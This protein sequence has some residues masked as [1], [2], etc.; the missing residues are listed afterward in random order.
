MEAR[1]ELIV[2]SHKSCPSLVRKDCDRWRVEVEA[3]LPSIVIAAR[4]GSGADLVD[5][6]VTIDDK[7]VLERLDGKAMPIDP[8]THKLRATMAGRSPVEKTFVAREGE[9]LR[10]VDLVFPVES[11]TTASSS[12]APPVRTV[13]GWTLVGAGGLAALLGTYL[14]VRQA[15]EYADAERECA[16]TCPM[17]RK[18]EIDSM[19]VYSGIAFGIGA[20]AIAGGV[21]LLL[22]K[23]APR[24]A[25][26]GA[27]GFVF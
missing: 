7:P 20:A 13:A 9:K 23:P 16:P 5:V 10:S 3:A 21:W 11:T 18:D 8:G 4:D 6:R 14:A 2:C 19:R 24:T 12:S 22:A 17:E 25:W 1:D 26:L 27:T 15:S